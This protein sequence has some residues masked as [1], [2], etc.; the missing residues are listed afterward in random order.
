MELW[1]YKYIYMFA[2]YIAQYSP[3]IMYNIILFHNRIKME[4]SIIPNPI[5]KII[6]LLLIGSFIYA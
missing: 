1:V 2:Y 5:L 4:H 6:L 3:I